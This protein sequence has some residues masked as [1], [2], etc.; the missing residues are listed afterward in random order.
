MQSSSY[1]AKFWAKSKNAG[2]IKWNDY[3]FSKPHAEIIGRRQRHSVNKTRSFTRFHNSDNPPTVAVFCNLI[4]TVVSVRFWYLY[5]PYRCECRP[6]FVMEVKQNNQRFLV[7][8]WKGRP[9][10]TGTMFSWKLIAAGRD[11]V[12]CT[13]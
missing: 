10:R 12:L 4:C 1:L 8:E 9:I 3:L 6:C 7:W 11:D 13:H 5:F 2:I